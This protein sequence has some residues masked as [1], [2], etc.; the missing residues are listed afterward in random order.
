MDWAVK[1]DY[2]ASTSLCISLIIMVL[3]VV[4]ILSPKKQLSRW[5]KPRWEGC[6]SVT[7]GRSKAHWILVT[8][9]LWLD[10]LLQIRCKSEGTGSPSMQLLILW[11]LIGVLRT[12]PSH[13]GHPG[14]IL[15]GIL[16]K[17]SQELRMLST[18]TLN[19]QATQI[20]MNSG[21]QSSELYLVSQVS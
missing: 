14:H 1:K 12:H 18:V 6:S 5:L 8:G 20:V 11:P 16:L 10:P 15:W 13:P 17:T 9:I 3:K 2:S 21:S 4:S 7:V 19:W